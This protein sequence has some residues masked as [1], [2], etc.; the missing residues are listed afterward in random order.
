[1]A[2]SL[3][4]FLVLLAGGIALGETTPMKGGLTQ[5]PPI[6]PV[7][8]SSKKPLPGPAPVPIEFTPAQAETKPAVLQTPTA[9]V[10]TPVQVVEPPAVPE[11]PSVVDALRDLQILLEPPS[12]QALFGKLDSEKMLEKR[13]AP[14]GNAARSTRYG[15]V[16]R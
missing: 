2:C 15:A 11:A 12:P 1:M 10:L 8:V 16:P 6:E 7:F 13:T 5:L 4:T 3:S 9:P 14:A